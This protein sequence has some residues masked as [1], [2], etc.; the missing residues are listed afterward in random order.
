MNLCVSRGFALGGG[1][2]VEAIFE[3]FNVM[4]ASNPARGASPVAGELETNSVGE[5]A[6][7][8]RS[9]RHRRRPVVQPD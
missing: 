5:N 3:M 2:R 7:A 1:A 6:V 8:S 4:N 9:E